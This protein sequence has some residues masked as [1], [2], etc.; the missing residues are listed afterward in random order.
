MTQTLT[1][2]RSA[3]AHAMLEEFEHEVG[4]TRRFLERLPDAKLSWKPHEK[5]MT[6]GQ[7][8]WHIAETHRR[9][10]EYIRTPGGKPPSGDRPQPAHVRDV[11]AELDSGAR[12]VRRL[13]SE[14]DDAW[15][16]SI[17]FIDAPDGSRIEVPRG[18]FLRAILFNH[19]Y[20]HRGQFGVYLRLL[21]VSV[22]SAYG[23]SGDEMGG[24]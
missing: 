8:A 13:L 16:Q 17:F 3:A 18:K 11:L 2:P 15:M 24:L 7:L 23:P 12:D 1:A 10:V 20:H 6:A 5:S 22:P 9:V 4:K 21:G 14:V 19:I